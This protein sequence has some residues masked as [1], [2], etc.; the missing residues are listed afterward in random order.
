MLHDIVLKGS[1]D[2][3]VTVR[4]FDSTTGVPKSDV[5]YNSSGIALWYRREGGAKVDITEATLAALTTA[6]T[7]GGFLLIGDGEYRLDLPD[8]AFATGANHVDFGGAVTGGVIVGGRVRLID[9][10][11]EDAV[12]MGLSA[13]P[14]AA[15]EAAGG[16]YTRGTGAGQ[17]A[18][19]ANGRINTN[20][21]AWRE[22][23]PNALSSGRV[24]VLLGAVTNGVIAAASFASN[25]LD[26]VWST[27]TRVLTAGTNIVLAKGTGV[28][29]FN[30]LSA[31]DV[32]AEVDT[33]LADYD[34]PT[35]AELDS[36]VAPLA[37]T[38]ALSDAQGDITSI[39]ADT[40]E[41]QTDWANG[42]RLDLILDSR[43]SQS[44]VDGVPT[45]AEFEARTLPTADYATA[46]ALAV[47]DQ[48]VD[49]AEEI[50]NKLDSMLEQVTGG[51]RWTDF[52]LS[53]APTGG[54]GGGDATEAKQDLILSRIGTPAVTLADDIA[55]I[56]AGSGL[57][58]A[59]V[60]AAIGLASANLDD[61]FAGLPTAAENADAV[62]DEDLTGHTTENSAGD[63]LGNV[64]TGTPPSASAIAD[65]VQ[66]RTIA[67][68]TTVTT[69]TND[70]G[71]TQGA[72]D[73]VWGSASRT[74]T[75]FGTLV[76]DIATAVWSA[77]TRI[78][79]AG[80]N[81]VLAKGTG[82]TGLNDLSAADVNAEVDG[83]IETY[84]LDHLL[85]VAYD[86][87][88]KPGA[89]DALLN[90]LVQNDGG[91]SQFTANAL[92]NAPT[93]GGPGGD[94]WLRDIDGKTAE[95][96][97]TILAGVAAGKTSIVDHGG[98]SATVTFR[99]VSDAGDVVEAE[100]QGSERVA[101]TV[102]P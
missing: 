46:A 23:Q 24:D 45:N 66:T 33:A 50:L 93:G 13:L 14:N 55:G 65:E 11:L 42:G 4:I 26:A 92:E 73:K 90:E 9:V 62:W 18:Q 12:R 81:I 30:D 6:H 94:P 100:M 72:A 77:T 51:Y 79:T 34:A 75:S 95:E 21:V 5:V 7:D 28:T 97:M 16:L 86:P 64:A 89:A 44:S 91:V 32:N 40:N 19:D 58:A 98:G 49:D 68:V 22:A 43:A 17:I 87:A 25:A 60:R 78:L 70:V 53:E 52:A 8:A 99:K 41:L 48:N 69:V 61:Q 36:A 31:A 71:I 1:T 102:T 2:R 56:S 47:V 29:G 80:T 20:L 35:K 74:L 37:T 10:N 54:G 84:H 96:I 15:A 39:L 67:A 59:G 85:A 101:V 82:I 76:A 57:D 3:S 38:S 27:A 88:S 63:V 83:A